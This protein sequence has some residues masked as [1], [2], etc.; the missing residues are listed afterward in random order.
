[1]AA[2]Q[3][4]VVLQLQRILASK[5]RLCVE[6]IFRGL[7]YADVLPAITV[8]IDFGYRFPVIVF[9]ARGR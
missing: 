9:S 7:E 3:H 6:R 8:G 1:M 4:F 5:F 2:G